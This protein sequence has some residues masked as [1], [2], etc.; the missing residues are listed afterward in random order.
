LFVNARKNID[1]VRVFKPSKSGFIE[2]SLVDSLVL[3]WEEF[4][5]TLL[6]MGSR[7]NK[8]DWKSGVVNLVENLNFGKDSLRIGTDRR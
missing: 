2:I 3:V 4:Q 8:E 5:S 7:V 6:V 1:N